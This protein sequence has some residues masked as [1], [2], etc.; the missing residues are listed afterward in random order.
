MTLL[1]LHFIGTALNLIETT[2]FLKKKKCNI[3]VGE[4]K[5]VYTT[6]NSTHTKYMYHMH[7]K[8]WLLIN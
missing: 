4:S 2:G 1:E 5:A 7:H 3:L 6:I 8:N